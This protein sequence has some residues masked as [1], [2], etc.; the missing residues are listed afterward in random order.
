DCHSPPGGGDGRIQLVGQ[1]HAC[2]ERG[3]LEHSAW[4]SERRGND[5]QA[6]LA[7]L[8]PQ[9][10]V[11]EQGD[12]GGVEVLDAPQVDHEAENLIRELGE[13]VE[14]LC[15]VGDVDLALHGGNDHPVSLVP[16]H[17][18]E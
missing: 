18:G 5:H 3:E 17:G 12:A 15:G 8:E 9:V 4:C 11:V 2:V 13:L 1:R 14:Q 16:A 6:L 7:A 10:Q